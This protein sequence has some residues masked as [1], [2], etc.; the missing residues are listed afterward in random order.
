MSIELKRSDL[1]FEYIWTRDNG[2][3]LSTDERDRSKIDLDEGYE[4]LHFLN[5][6]YKDLNINIKIE[7]LYIEDLLYQKPGK[8]QIRKDIK[9]WIKTQ[10]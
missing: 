5:S 9:D 8:L 10:I 6:L 4:V 2:D 3:S 1:K 7:A